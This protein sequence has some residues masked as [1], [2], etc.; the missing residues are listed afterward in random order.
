M[1]D[2]GGVYRSVF[3]PYSQSIS[4]IRLL[5]LPYV[6]VVVFKQKAVVLVECMCRLTGESEVRYPNTFDKGEV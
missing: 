4:L 1:T 3:S 2:G 6:V 5:L